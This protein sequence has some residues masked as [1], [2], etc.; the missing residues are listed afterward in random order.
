MV[1]T[2]KAHLCIFFIVAHQ[3]VAL[4]VQNQLI[5]AD[6]LRR[7]L[8]QRFIPTVFVVIEGDTA[9]A[10]NRLVDKL[11]VIEQIVIV[12]FAP[13]VYGVNVFYVRTEIFVGKRAKLVDDLLRM[14]S[15]NLFTRQ[16]A[17]NE[18]TQL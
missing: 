11:H 10:F 12:R 8:F 13:I 14:A 16:N 1:K 9:G 5:G 2:V 4:V 17:V 6:R 18:H 3:I 7:R 15:R